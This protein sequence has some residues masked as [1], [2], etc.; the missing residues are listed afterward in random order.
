MAGLLDRVLGVPLSRARRDALMVN[1][2]S[3]RSGPDAAAYVLA[4][5]QHNTEK[6]G[7]LLA[8]QG[9]FAIACTYG[10]DHGWP[11]SLAIAAILLL[12]AG[13]MLAMSMLRS[14]A[15]PFRHGDH[16][17]RMATM[18]HVL[19]S[20]MV[21]FNIAL[22]CTFLSVLLLGIAAIRFAY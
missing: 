16:D 10:L 11:R 22:Y 17:A 4:G 8:A 19:I 6:A 14:T 20:R 3:G 7:A 2:I 9:I 21:R 12:V 5:V 13:A 15:A 1:T 18:F